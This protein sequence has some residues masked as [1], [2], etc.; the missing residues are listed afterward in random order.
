MKQLVPQ[1]PKLDERGNID[2]AVRQLQDWGVLVGKGACNHASFEALRKAVHEHFKVPWTSITPAME[3]LLYAICA[4]NRPRNIVAVG[5][6]CGN[7]LIWNIGPACGPGKCYAAQRLVG[8]EV[9]P[10]RAG[11]ARDNLQAIGVMDS[12]EVIAGDGHEILREI[13]YP[14]HLLYLDCDC[15]YKP[16]LD[17]AYDK[18]S[19]GGLVIAHNTIHKGWAKQESSQEYLAHVRDT[20]VFRE[21]VSV[22]PDDLGI[23][24][25]VR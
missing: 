3:R 10:D 13:D 4:V 18:V 22:E 12:V 25:S 5:I 17:A 8:I 14:I 24:V 9:Q 20:S 21:S 11:M 16:M 23:E 19:E 6:F 2:E 7:T 1:N 15:P